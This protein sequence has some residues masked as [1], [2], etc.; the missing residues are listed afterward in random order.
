MRSFG[1]GI[2]AKWVN[3]FQ[4][5]SVNSSLPP[6]CW[7]TIFGNVQLFLAHS[8]I[9]WSAVD[10]KF[11]VTHVTRGNGESKS[12]CRQS[13]CTTWMFSSHSGRHCGADYGAFLPCPWGR[14]EGMASLGFLSPYWLG[15]L[16][17][18]SRRWD[19]RQRGWD[20][21]YDWCLLWLVCDP[22]PCPSFSLL[23]PATLISC[24]FSPQV[25]PRSCS[26]PCNP[27]HHATSLQT[28]VLPNF[29]SDM[30]WVWHLFPA[31]NRS[32]WSR[33]TCGPRM[34]TGLCF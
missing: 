33:H 10:R 7:K 14:P 20:I 31:R 1:Q 15:P 16:G 23:A 12:S 29:F 4:A 8:I 22:G 27:P 18:S 6:N 11:C 17:I 24:S 5:S 34:L 9:L 25:A 30:I 19:K 3:G 26:I 32:A 2:S 21:Y 28:M 13:D